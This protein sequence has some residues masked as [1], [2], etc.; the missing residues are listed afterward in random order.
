MKNKGIGNNIKVINE[1]GQEID[2]SIAENVSQFKEAFLKLSRKAEKIGRT[3]VIESYKDISGELDILK[4]L[5]TVNNFIVKD[6]P[7]LE[8]TYLPVLIR[9]ISLEKAIHGK[10]IS[11]AMKRRKQAGGAVGN[12]LIT[13]YAKEGA[14]K[15]RKHQALFHPS[16]IEAAENIFQLLREDK[17]NNSQ[18]ANELNK[19][20]IKTRRGGKFFSKSVERIID[21]YRELKSNFELNNELERKIRIS[22]K[23]SK[24]SVEGLKDNYERDASFKITI[25]NHQ[26]P[27]KVK[28]L[29]NHFNNVLIDDHLKVD[30]DKMIID[31]N[32]Q[33]IGDIIHL[34]PGRY[35]FLITSDDT[36]QW[37]RFC[38]SFTVAN[39]LEELTTID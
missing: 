4:R 31:F 10:K 18:I 7:D 29:D 30:K 24:F 35:Y 15:K 19:R 38:Q 27:I 11:K 34:I 9:H 16:N 32:N 25:S 20:N 14:V 33:T 23:S 12:P 1:D 28:I 37:T 26:D 8:K 2:G 36:D 5:L 3:L 13:K 22:H 6:F 39:S 21:K 17:Y